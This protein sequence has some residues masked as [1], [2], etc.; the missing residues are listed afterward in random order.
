M[1]AR[2][3][4]FV[5]AI[6]LLGTLALTTA[7]TSRG[8][9]AEAPLTLVA[10]TPDATIEMQKRRA[11]AKNASDA[12]AIAALSIIATLADRASHGVAEQAIA[13]VASAT[14]GEIKSDA[15]VLA[16]AHAPDEGTAVG[17]TKAQA[18]GILTDVAIL[19]P[20]RDTG[21]GLCH[22]AQQSNAQVQHDCLPDG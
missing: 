19:G 9:S 1:T 5:P 11:V 4:P 13:G 16:R 6:A 17:V 18:A 12:D 21:G 22:Q 10:E 20:F 7:A 3:S 14:S 2:L 8:Q 15:S